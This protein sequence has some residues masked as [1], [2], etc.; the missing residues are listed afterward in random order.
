MVTVIHCPKQDTLETK[1][2]A[3]KNY[4]GSTGR[5]G[6]G[7]VSLPMGCPEE[8]SG[9]LRPTLGRIRGPR[10]MP[11]CPSFWGHVGVIVLLNSDQRIPAKFLNS[12][13]AAFLTRTKL[14]VWRI[15]SIEFP[16]FTETHFSEGEILVYS[17]WLRMETEKS[18]LSSSLL[19]PPHG[20]PNH[21]E[22]GA[23][24]G[25]AWLCSE[26]HVLWCHC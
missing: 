18:H 7:T 10:A 1:R 4:R 6:C 22:A 14:S 13:S 26:L 19:P 25:P 9:V 17:L 12:S 16:V 15:G 21:G 5:P 2:K 24:A 23:G 8:G 20:G 3:T 11:T